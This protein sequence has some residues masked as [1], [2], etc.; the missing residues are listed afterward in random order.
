MRRYV[1]VMQQWPYQSYYYHYK[2][3]MKGPE[4]PSNLPRAAQCEQVEQG[5]ELESFCSQEE[6]HITAPTATPLL[7]TGYQDYFASASGHT[8]FP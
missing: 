5:K 6:A 2:Q 1:D 7:A 3:L 4:R 8:V